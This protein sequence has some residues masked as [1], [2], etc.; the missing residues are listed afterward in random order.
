MSIFSEQNIERA[1]RTYEGLSSAARYRR[2]TT[3]YLV[4][5]REG[6]PMRQEIE[7]W[8]PAFAPGKRRGLVSDVRALSEQLVHT[9]HELAVGNKL[10][11]LGFE[12][13]YELRIDHIRAEL[14]LDALSGD[15]NGK[16]PDWYV[17]RTP[18]TP[19]FIADVFTTDIPGEQPVWTAEI[20]QLEQLLEQLPVDAEIG[21]KP[22]SNDLELPGNFAPAAEGRVRTWIETDDPQP[23]AS[24]VVW[25]TGPDPF[26]DGFDGI[27][28]P[29]GTP[30][31]AR[32]GY[33]A[34]EITFTMGRRGQGFAHV[35]ASVWARTFT[36]DKESLRKNIKKKAEYYAG[37]CL[38]LV[39]AVVA[40]PMT[41][42]SRVEFEEVLL[43]SR[44]MAIE[45]GGTQT[46]EVPY[47]ESD[48]LLNAP[49]PERQEEEAEPGG[50]SE[51][52]VMRKALSMAIFLERLVEDQWELACVQ[53]PCA[54]W[55]LP[56]DA[57]CAAH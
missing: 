37:A 50:Y 17:R 35:K 9:Y 8:V 2:S 15:I 30:H 57:L 34:H 14:G 56:A 20:G 13:E 4:F 47:R 49:P 18:R 45:G 44:A 3:R 5:D 54:Q 31:R 1:H 25:P 33:E 10:R 55:P 40:D 29:A 38:P 12:I 46:V 22:P 41:G 53:N 7:R 19:A 26:G 42:V 39:V 21:I 43:G 48:G 52:E 16:K 28:Y 11:E 36:V 24:Y 27:A 6:E 23:D 32:R 51:G